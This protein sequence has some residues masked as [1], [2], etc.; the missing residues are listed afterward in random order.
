MLSKCRRDQWTV[1]DLE[2]VVATSIE[3]RR[4]EAVEAVVR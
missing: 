3:G 1:D 4:A 2:A